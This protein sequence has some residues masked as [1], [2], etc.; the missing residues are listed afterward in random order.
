MR[1]FLRFA[2][3]PP[4]TWFGPREWLVRVRT[5]ATPIGGDPTARFRM[6][7]PDVAAPG[8]KLEI[9]ILSE[10][11]LAV[12]VPESPWDPENARLRG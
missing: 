10:R 5:P 12:V 9:E 3:S 8:T 11:F 1:Y 2:A 6:Q 4:A 7:R